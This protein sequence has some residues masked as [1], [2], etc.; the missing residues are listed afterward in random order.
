MDVDTCI[1][2]KVLNVDDQGKE[3]PMPD[4]IVFNYS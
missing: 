3:L 1:N 2:C 4:A